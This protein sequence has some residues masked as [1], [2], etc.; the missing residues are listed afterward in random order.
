M[1]SL[2]FEEKSENNKY[3]DQIRLSAGSAVFVGDKAEPEHWIKVG[4][5]FPRFA[6]QATAIGI[7][8]AHINRP[9]EVPEVRAEISSWLGVGDARPDLV[10]R[11]GRANPL[12]M[13]ARRPVSAV[14]LP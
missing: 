13:S 6:L 10:V 11:F 12:P 9:A 4:R 1:C 5:S 7:R 2:V 14:L 8:N 3:R